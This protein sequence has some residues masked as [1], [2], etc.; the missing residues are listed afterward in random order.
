M[1]P[2]SM[3]PLCE[4][5]NPKPYPKQTYKQH[6]TPENLHHKPTTPSYLHLQS[7]HTPLP[8]T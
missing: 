8:H 2:S 1:P 4:G 5:G 3:S 6:P 7:Y